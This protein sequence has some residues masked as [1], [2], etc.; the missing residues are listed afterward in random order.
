MNYFR[1]VVRDRIRKPLIKLQRVTTGA[2]LRVGWRCHVGS[3]RGRDARL[4]FGT[5]RGQCVRTPDA[6]F[7][8]TVRPGSP[9]F[10]HR[11]M[12]VAAN[13][14]HAAANWPEKIRLQMEVMVELNGS[15]VAASGSQHVE[16]G[17][18]PLEAIDVLHNGWFAASDRQ[19]R[20]TPRAIRV[21][22]G[23]KPNGSPVVSVAKS[24]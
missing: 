2:G 19:V 4:V 5:I 15:R 10:S 18:I 24:T 3:R 7:C 12:A 13:Q 17:M 16:F 6:T 14:L 8:I 21:A 20:M 11:T 22:R 1:L 9:S 23:G